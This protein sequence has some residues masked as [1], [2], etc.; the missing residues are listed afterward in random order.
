M[1]MEENRKEAVSSESS[2]FSADGWRAPYSVA[3]QQEAEAWRER[4]REAEEKYRDALSDPDRR[5]DALRTVSGEVGPVPEMVRITIA[6][7]MM[8][9]IAALMR[10]DDEKKKEAAW[11][12]PLRPLGKAAPAGKWVCPCCGEENGGR[13]CTECGTKRP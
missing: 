1:K 11:P 12:A 9:I 3:D 6:A 13:F 7:S 8:P 2:G 4:L 10:I 5:D